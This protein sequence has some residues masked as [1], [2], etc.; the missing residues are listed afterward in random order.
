MQNDCPQLTTREYPGKDP[1][2][3]VMQR[4]DEVNAPLPCTAVSDNAQEA[5]KE[6]Y[7]HNIQ[8]V[9]I[10]GGKNTLEKFLTT[11]LWDE[12]RILVGNRQWGGG[13]PAPK[14]PGIL[15]KT[16]NIDDNQLM[17]VRRHV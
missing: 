11:D 2:R 9:I 6:L 8:S 16:V 12:A 4:G 3:F 13:L 15:D 17:Y 14:L 5:V 1:Q 7:E 10:E